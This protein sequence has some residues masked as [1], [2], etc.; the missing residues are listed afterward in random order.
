MKTLS[1]VKESGSLEPILVDLENIGKAEYFQQVLAA[2]SNSKKYFFERFKTLFSETDTQEELDLLEDIRLII[3][4]EEKT[5][6]ETFEGF[7]RQVLNNK[8]FKGV[9]LSA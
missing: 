7:A 5:I 1:L 3:F 4:N 6:E 8:F 2:S 9:E